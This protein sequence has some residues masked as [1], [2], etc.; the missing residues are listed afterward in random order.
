MKEK[1]ER[2]WEWWRGGDVPSREDDAVRERVETA[3][4][5]R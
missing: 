1:N 5:R 3:D 2:E 4:R